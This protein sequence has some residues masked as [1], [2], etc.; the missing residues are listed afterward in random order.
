MTVR[1]L[2][3]LASIEVSNVDK[4]S[5]EGETPVLLCNYTDVYYNEAITSD[6]AFMEATATPE[7]ISRF[8]LEAGDTL[9]TKDSETPE[10]IA[11]PAY[12]ANDMPGVL[13]GYH[14]AIAR[15]LKVEPRYLYW[16]LASQVVREQM[17]LAATGVTRH[18]LRQDLM[19]R[20][21]VPVPAQAIQRK[22]ARFL[23]GEI[24][25]IN[26]VLAKKRRLVDL[27]QERI[28]SEI[29]GLVG[30]SELAGSNGT[31]LAIP[32]RRGLVKVNRPANGPMITAYRDGQ[33]TARALRRSDGYTES[34]TDGARVQGVSMRDVVVHGLDGFAGAIGTAEVDGV[35]S[36]VYHVCVPADGGD[37]H[38]YGRLLRLLATTGYLGL[39]ASSTRERAVDF[40][41]WDLF[42]RIP[43]PKVDVGDQR[44]IGERIRRLA[45]LRI[46]VERSA[47]L[48]QERKE[49]LITAAVTGQLDLAREIAEEAS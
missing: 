23:D 2:K 12:V 4:H 44:R 20:V 16:A 6:L 40:R 19:G 45:P 13:C 38:F 1:P 22:V 7:Q 42:G 11:V 24:A 36:P 8:T 32:L 15:P 30:C 47:E 29:M 37:S 41:N 28:D 5:V 31:L 25:R 27:M 49:A 48:V 9:F 3:F 33:V 43:I 18:G 26:D 10:D 21:P 34:W 35:C 46:V 39:F 14:L 17:S